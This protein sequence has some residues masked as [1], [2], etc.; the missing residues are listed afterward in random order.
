MSR[1]AP[2]APDVVSRL[3][4]YF[5]GATLAER[6]RAARTEIRGRVVFTTSFGIEDQAIAHALFSEGL[7]VEVTTLDTGRLFPETHEVWA[8]TERRYGKR[9]RGF[10]PNQQSVEALVARDGIDGIRASFAARHACCHVRKV[11]P[12]GRALAGA[13]GW[14][15]G[16]RAD[17]SASRAQTE[18]VS[19]EQ[20]RGLIKINPLLDWSRPQVV[21]FV[22]QHAVPYNALHD[23][24]F[25]SI[26]CAPC[27][28]AVAPGEPERAGR[29]WWEQEEKKECGLHVSHEARRP[30]PVAAPV[31]EAAK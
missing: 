26:G 19:F 28:R 15:T 18:F 23:R 9:I 22:R 8:A 5:A 24:G 17:Q 3:A 13:A 11:V 4:A 1:A 29:W 12:L 10:A 25:L 31:L 16:L 7:D 30:A 6:L 21:D 2:Q 14:I 27:T 20:E